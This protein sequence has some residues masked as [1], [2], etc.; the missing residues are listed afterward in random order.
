MLGW[1]GAAS[2]VGRCPAPALI[3]RPLGPLA[4]INRSHILCSPITFPLLSVAVPS[5]RSSVCFA[6]RHYIPFHLATSS[7]RVLYD[8]SYITL[9]YDEFSST[10]ELSTLNL[11]CWRK[12]RR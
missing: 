3:A 12:P 7:G 6:S 11:V 9:T 1:T 4:H 2:K 5:S 8:V 10:R